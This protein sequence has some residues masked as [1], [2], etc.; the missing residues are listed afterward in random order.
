MNALRFTPLNLIASALVLLAV[1]SIAR[2]DRPD[3]VKSYSVTGRPTVHV[4]TNDG[5]LRVITSDSNQ[6]EFRVRTEG[7]A[8]GFGFQEPSITS[9]QDG[10]TVELSAQFKSYGIG[11][12]SLHNSID[13]RMPKNADLQLDTGDGSVELSSLN[14]NIQI[15]TADGSVKIGQLVGTIDVSTSD[16]SIQAEGLKG[17]VKV[18]SHDGSVRVAEVDGK[19]D[20]SSNDGSVKVEGRLDAL[21]IHTDNGSV[22]ARVANGSSISSA[23]H[24]SSSDGS[25]EIALPADMKANLDVSTSDG[26][27][28]LNLPVQ[29]QGEMSKSHVSGTLNGGGPPV[30]IHSSDG[31]IT[32]SAT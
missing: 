4:H 22:K 25:V 30:L 16:G 12:S 29:V 2:A 28:K 15:H 14:G 17:A 21:N 1:T 24:V 26:R 7:S 3:W 20:A 6:V 5:A 27:I 11:F 31:S 18:H 10:D 23:W 19:C 9:H 32:I 13:V 8:F